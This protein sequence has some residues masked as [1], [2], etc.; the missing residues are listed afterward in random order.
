VVCTKNISICHSE[1]FGVSAI[2]DLYA[3]L[4]YRAELLGLTVIVSPR[5]DLEVLHTRPASWAQTPSEQFDY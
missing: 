1:K 2:V 5:S 3:H 4:I